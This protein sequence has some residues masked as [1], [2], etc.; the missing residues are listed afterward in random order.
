MRVLDPN[1]DPL[2]EAAVGRIGSALW[3]HGQPPQLVAVDPRGLLVVAAHPWSVSVWDLETRVCAAQLTPGELGDGVGALAF[4][5]DASA[6]LVASRDAV[7]RVARYGEVVQRLELPAAATAR[8]LTRI[9]DAWWLVRSRDDG[10]L[11]WGRLGSKGLGAVRQARLAEEARVARLCGEVVVAGSESGAQGFER[12][13]G[14]QLWRAKASGAAVRDSAAFPDASKV[15]VAFGDG[16]VRIY[17]ASSGRVSRELRVDAEEAWTVAVSPSGRKLFA[18]SRSG[19]VLLQDLEAESSTEPAV[20]EHRGCLSCGAFASDELAVVGVEHALQLWDVSSVKPWPLASG[21]LGALRLVAPRADGGLVTWSE[22]N[23]VRLW[24]AGGHEATP[25]SGTGELMMVCVS[26]DGTRVALASNPTEPDDAIRVFDAVTGK[27]VLGPM[28]EWGATC[29]CFS[30]DNSLLLVGTMGGEVDLFSLRESERRRTI[31]AHAQSIGQLAASADGQWMVTLPEFDGVPRLWDLRTGERGPPLAWNESGSQVTAVAISPHAPLLATGHA[32]GT[33]RLFEIKTGTCRAAFE[34]APQQPLK[35]ICFSPKGDLLGTVSKHGE[36]LVLWRLDPFTRLAELVDHF[37]VPGAVAFCH[38]EMRCVT[39][40]EDASVVIWDIERALAKGSPKVP[41]SAPIEP[42]PQAPVALDLPPPPAFPL[43]TGRPPKDF[44]LLFEAPVLLRGEYSTKLLQPALVGELSVPSRRFA[45]GDPAAL[46]DALPFTRDVEPGPH[47]VHAVMEATGDCAEPRALVVSFSA[48]RVAHW[49]PALGCFDDG[50][51]VAAPIDSAHIALADA[52][53]VRSAHQDIDG[54]PPVV[55]SFEE[56]SRRARDSAIACVRLGDTA[57]GVVVAITGSDGGY[58][59]WWG[60]NDEGVPCRLVVDLGAQP[61]R[62]SLFDGPNPL[63]PVPLRDP[64]AGLEWLAAFTEN[65][66][67]R[68]GCLAAEERQALLG[69]SEL[70]AL[71]ADLATY[72]DVCTPWRADASLS[73]WQLALRHLPHPERSFPLAFDG[74]GWTVVA[75]IDDAGNTAITG[76][77]DG[78]AYYSGSNIFGFWLCYVAQVHD[79][80]R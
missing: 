19:R 21:P 80:H 48:A 31:A 52:G 27:C 71:P 11:L 16:T 1:G 41:A 77:S 54:K 33:L 38:D 75:R 43:G 35:H 14:R 46:S 66:D 26:P 74:Q 17:E 50:Q 61:D 22:P 67:V 8:D 18:G 32:D 25:L 3:R 37:G 51:A 53:V 76:Y 56:A 59:A 5:P 30:A 4:E 12:R 44:D 36:G 64:R 34:A 29:G 28:G 15:A 10:T 20:L 55:T 42:P 2:A 57:R 49:E 69:L 68:S 23:L 13:S 47:A 40:S 72:Y 24:D 45:L 73:S 79:W 7:C 78:S 6:F 70:D 60:L 62:S 9:E 39:G 58:G 65:E 63:L